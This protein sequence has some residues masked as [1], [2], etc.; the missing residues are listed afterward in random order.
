M[1]YGPNS[2][3]NWM[4]D[5]K[6]IQ[7]ALKQIQSW[8]GVKEITKADIIKNPKQVFGRYSITFKEIKK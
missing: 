5:F 8:L 1:C 4:K 3:C 6:T 2:T 7:G